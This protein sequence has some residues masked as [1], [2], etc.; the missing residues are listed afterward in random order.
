MRLL[1]LLV[2]SLGLML[3]MAGVHGPAAA[4]AGP[5]SYTVTAVADHE[6]LVTGGTLTVTGVVRPAAP[7]RPVR[8]QQRSEGEWR[9]IATTSLDA[10][11]RYSLSAV[12]EDL[13]DQRLRVVKAALGAVG[14]GVSPVVV[15]NVS[16]VELA[17]ETVILTDQDLA[18]LESFDLESGRLELDPEADVTDVRIGSILAGGY[19]ERTPNGLLRRVT[20]IARTPEGG[21]ALA[22]EQA[23]LNQA[24]VRTVGAQHVTGTLEKQ[25]AAPA[26]GVAVDRAKRP[27]GFSASLPFPDLTFSLKSSATVS[28]PKPEDGSGVWGQGT[29]SL[30]SDLK[31]QSSAE[32]VWEQGP[33]GVDRVR[34]AF[35]TATTTTTTTTVA[36]EVHGT[37]GASMGE[38]TRYYTFPLGPIPVVI[39]DTS[40]IP[41][42]IELSMTAGAETSFE[43]TDTAAVGFEYTRGHGVSPVWEHDG[44]HTAEAGGAQG[45][46]TLEASAGLKETT[47]IYGLVGLTASM[48]AYGKY[49]ADV[50]GLACPVT[51]GIRIGGGVAAGVDILIFELEWEWTAEDDIELYR[52]DDCALNPRIKTEWL[53]DGTEGQDY[54]TT[55]ETEDDRT[56]YWGHEGSLPPGLS[57]SSSG[58]LSGTPQQ[59]GAFDVRVTFTDMEGRVIKMTLS[60]VVQPNVLLVATGSLPNGVVGVPYA[61]VLSADGGQGP[62]TWTVLSGSVPGLTVNP[63]GSVTGEPESAGAGTLHVQVADADGL[64]AEGDVSWSVTDL[65][66]P[67]S[68]TGTGPITA[69]PACL[70][71][72][73]TSWGDPHLVTYDGL[74]YDDQLAGELVLTRSTADDFEVQVRQ[75]PW[76]GSQ[77]VAVNT[78]TAMMVDGTRV[79]IYLTPTGVR[80]LV[81]GDPVS[82]DGAGRA[83]PGGGSIR[84]DQPGHLVVVSWADGTS[85]SASYVPGSYITIRMSLTTDRLGTLRGLLGD[86][87]GDRS[88]DLST[89]DGDVVAVGSTADK[90]HSDFADTWRLR[91]GESLFDYAEGESTESFV[92]RA[93]PHVHVSV[94]DLP[95]AQA[96]AAFAS[97]EAS[98]VVGQAALDSCALDVALSGDED[99]AAGALVMQSGTG[100]GGVGNGSFEDPAIGSRFVSLGVGAT[101]GAWT[102][103]SGSVDLVHS[104]YWQP[105][106]GSQSLDLNSCSPGRIAQTMAVEP[107]QRYRIAYSYAGN[108]ET[109]DRLKKFHVEVDGAVVD[110]RTFDT[111]G[112]TTQSMGWTSAVT[113]FVATG[114]RTT[115]AFQ[116]DQT[117]SCGGAALDDIVITPVSTSST[118]IASSNPGD[119]WTDQTGATGLAELSYGHSGCS[120]LDVA[121]RC[122]SGGWAVVDDAPWIWAHQFP[123]NGEGTV[124]FTRTVTLSEAQAGHL[125]RLTA[126]G[127]DVMTASVDGRQVLSGGFTSPTSTDL[128]LSPGEHVL[129][130]AVTNLGGYQPTSNPGGLAWKLRTVD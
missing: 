125:L 122:V 113:A 73:G 47:K 116:S 53:P 76:N 13:G 20:D 50:D 63:D 69:P 89:R 37:Y 25:V 92:D 115:I 39:T 103:V 65:P 81:D 41:F 109:S 61:G 60:L 118:V 3:L 95:T 111:T 64:V 12:L 43:S 9:T 66:P 18:H 80:T 45:S 1:R 100:A 56:G 16:S 98:G 108:P 21:W 124:T 5:P 19:S 126:L 127:D 112:R 38:V 59:E 2:A 99:M 34:A 30:A 71:A 129:T 104:S 78:A 28:T 49:E 17:D 82:V 119:A 123:R 52:Q 7:Y 44:S 31:F 79:G 106:A 74:S 51:A 91:A 35:H 11:S 101:M 90:I 27:Q 24:I 102:V 94:S 93:F 68:G 36:G 88:D 117:G 14:V 67:V 121:L 10:H 96:D 72:C 87:D 120:A 29:Y 110:R 77:L 62:Y 75:Q 40:E 46:V 22:T 55:L 83:L 85:L 84:H 57:L 128:T 54:S 26:E 130:F 15:V 33:F 105:A 58:T 97:C 48:L 70:A 4:A 8:L 86:A 42:K 6:Y 107:G 114:D 23:S 32:L